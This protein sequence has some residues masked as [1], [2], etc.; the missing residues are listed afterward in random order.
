[1]FPV[2]F[3]F[4]QPKWRSFHPLKGLTKNLTCYCIQS[5]VRN[6]LVTFVLPQVLVWSHLSIL[7]TYKFI[8]FRNLSWL[9]LKIPGSRL[10]NKFDGT[11]MY[12]LVESFLPL[13]LRAQTQHIVGLCCWEVKFC[14]WAIRC[15]TKQYHS[16]SYLWVLGPEYPSNKE[17]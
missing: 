8:C 1:M 15:N 3:S 16:L 14:K 9:E 11:K 12:P 17:A 10:R 7:G 4:T 13:V 6:C 5:Q 2:Q